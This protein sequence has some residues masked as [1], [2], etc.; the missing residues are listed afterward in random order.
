ML[1]S[2]FDQLDILFQQLVDELAN[3]NA[4]GAGADNQIGFHVGFQIHR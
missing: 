3:V 1:P 2:R 4:A